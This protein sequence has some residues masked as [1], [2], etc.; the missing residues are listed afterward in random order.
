MHACTPKGGDGRPATFK[1]V[2]ARSVDLLTIGLA[3]VAPVWLDRDATLDKI[4]SYIGQA[5]DEGCQLV[6]FGEALAPG[7]PFWLELTDGARFDHPPQKKMFSWYLDQGVVI[8]RGDLDKVATLC[9]QRSIAAYIGIIERPPERGGHSLYCSLVHIAASGLVSSVH[10][11]LQPTYEERL[12]WAAGDGHGLRVHDVG[13]FR[14]GGL[15]CYE[16]WMPLVRSALYA[17]GEDLHVAVWPGNIRNTVDITRF[18]AV[19]SRSFVASVSGI[20]RATD[21]PSGTPFRDELLEVM[22]TTTV[23]ADGG[24]CIAAPDGTWV[25]EPAVLD[26]QLITAQIDHARVR[27]ARQNF[28]LA[29]HYSRPDVTR[30]HVD[31]TRQTTTTFFDPGDGPAGR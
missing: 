1:P 3:Q 8:E 22:G 13:A 21:I 2:N 17:Q 15:N 14:V 28:D 19:E 29:G 20:L 5:A 31:R 27:E 26:E 18:I 9:G 11:K 16:N 6:V 23:L 25:V 30:L 10:R 12:A 7:Y 4:S 24:T